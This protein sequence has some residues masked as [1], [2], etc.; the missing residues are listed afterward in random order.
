[1]PDFSLIAVLEPQRKQSER[2]LKRVTGRKGDRLKKRYFREQ[3][4]FRLL[5]HFT[6]GTHLLLLGRYDQ[7]I[8]LEALD[9]GFPEFHE[10]A[11]S[12]SQPLNLLGPMRAKLYTI[13]GRD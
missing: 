9:L 6:I 7:R 4:I 3:S 13:S 10:L 12:S 11:C 8:S 1:M 2:V 5:V